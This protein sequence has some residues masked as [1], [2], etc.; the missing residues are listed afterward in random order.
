P[1]GERAVHGAGVQVAQAQPAG[2]LAADAGLPRSGG[3]VDGDDQVAGGRHATTSETGGGK[4]KG[5]ATIRKQGVY[6]PSACTTQPS[7]C[8]AS[9]SPASA[10]GV[11]ASSTRPTGWPGECSIRM[12]SML[13]PAP[14]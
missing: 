7:A 8:S 14:P 5:R 1:P 11:T 2:H 10:P 13:T 9:T 4:G 12:S 3:P 6:V